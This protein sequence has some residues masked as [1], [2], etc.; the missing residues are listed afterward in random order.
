[1][2]DKQSSSSWRFCRGKKKP[3]LE[4]VLCAVAWY[5]AQLSAQICNGMIFS[6]IWIQHSLYQHF[7]DVHDVPRE[8]NV[9]G[10]ANSSA[11]APCLKH[12]PICS[13]S[14][15]WCLIENVKRGPNWIQDFAEMLRNSL[16]AEQQPSEKGPTQSHSH[17][18]F[19]VIFTLRVKTGK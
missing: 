11:W 10:E 16:F 9:L 15:P 12:S 8:L 18:S 6:R 1:M 17:S 5:H 19:C 13:C 2:K 4:T 7:L 3:T 14:S